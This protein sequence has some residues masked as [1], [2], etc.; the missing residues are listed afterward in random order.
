MG[1]FSLFMSFLFTHWFVGILSSFVNNFYSKRVG[2][3]MM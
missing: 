3:A 1:R 2:F